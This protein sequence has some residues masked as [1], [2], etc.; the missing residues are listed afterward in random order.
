MLGLGPYLDGR[1]RP[2]RRPHVRGA[3]HPGPGGG[4]RPGH[5]ARRPGRAGPHRFCPGFAPHSPDRT[6]L[7]REAPRKPS[8]VNNPSQFPPHRAPRLRSG[9]RPTPVSKSPVLFSD[10]A[11]RWVSSI[12][13]SAQALTFGQ[14]IGRRACVPAG[15]PQH[16]RAEDGGHHGR[17]SRRR[18]G[19]AAY[20]ARPRARA[21]RLRAPRATSGCASIP[22]ST[23]RGSRRIPATT[24]AG[25][26]PNND[27]LRYEIAPG[28]G[29]ASCATGGGV[30]ALGSGHRGIP[31]ETVA[32]ARELDAAAAPARGAGPAPGQ[33]HPRR[34]FYA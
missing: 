4:R 3:R 27:F 29:A 10:Y 13:D 33:L 1:Q 2:G 31:K 23:P 19:R 30:P 24:S 16:A 22:A 25:E 32:L 14:V 34:L 7:S 20:A 28:T 26:R 18:K 15:R 8:R 21:G 11:S 6:E 5:P 17:L 12:P 9:P